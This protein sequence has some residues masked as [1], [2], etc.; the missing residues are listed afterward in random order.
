MGATQSI[1]GSCNVAKAMIDGKSTT[2]EALMNQLSFH[3]QYDTKQMS[4]LLTLVGETDR[5]ALDTIGS[6][7]GH[8]GTIYQT[9]STSCNPATND[10]AK[11]FHSLANN[12]VDQA[13]H[14]SRAMEFSRAVDHVS[15]KDAHE[16][17]LRTAYDA[18]KGTNER[19]YEAYKTVAKLTT[20]HESTF[21]K[22]LRG[23]NDTQLLSK[24]SEFKD[25]EDTMKE[26]RIAARSLGENLSNLTKQL[27]ATVQVCSE[28]DG[29][30]PHKAVL[31]PCA[32]VVLQMIVNT[33]GSMKA[34]I[35]LSMRHDRG[36]H[37]L[38]EKVLEEIKAIETIF[39]SLLNDKVLLETKTLTI[40]ETH[41][42][43]LF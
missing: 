39:E 32:T 7:N 43:Y 29:G 18:I 31:G 30:E 16:M 36:I 37:G 14:F 22:Q 40:V 38:K 21:E 28:L 24:L 6:L 17:V 19:T 1:Q 4:P 2:C 23:L 11:V 35:N 9:L 10:N 8:I 42:S 26:Y 27:G 12:I 25:C 34:V 5:N 33:L 20:E 15:K 41:S 3:K 13:K